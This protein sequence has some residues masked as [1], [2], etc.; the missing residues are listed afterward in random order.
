MTRKIFTVIAV[1]FIACG[2]AA[3]AEDYVVTKAGVRIQD[4]SGQETTELC[5]KFRL[6]SSDVRTYFALA[7]RVSDRAYNHDL[8]MSQCRSLGY[9]RKGRSGKR[10]SWSIDME[11][12]GMITDASGKQIYYYCRRCSNPLFDEVYDP[13]TE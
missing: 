11:R 7:E 9:I 12:R 1:A 8:E 5:R 13:D 6:T 2:G 10:S 4:I 3:A